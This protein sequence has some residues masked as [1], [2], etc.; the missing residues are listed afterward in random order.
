MAECLSGYR[1]KDNLETNTCASAYPQPF[2]I[3]DGGSENVHLKVKKVITS[4]LIEIN[5]LFFL[6]KVNINMLGTNHLIV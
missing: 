6:L 4:K 1:L 2:C 5:E 3:N